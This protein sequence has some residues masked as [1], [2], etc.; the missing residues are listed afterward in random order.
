MIAT[1]ASIVI[2]SFAMIAENVK[3]V[4][5]LHAIIV[6][7][8]HGMHGMTMEILHR[9]IAQSVDILTATGTV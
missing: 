1:I 5:L 2:A 6:A 4:P 3:V 8:T 7:N 9:E